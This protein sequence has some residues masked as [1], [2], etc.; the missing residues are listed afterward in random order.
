MDPVTAITLISTGL[1]VVDQYRELALRLRGAVATPPSSRAEQAGS[2]LQISHGQHV[3]TRVEAAQLRMNEWDP[4]RYDALRRR[5]RTNWEIFNVLFVSEAAGANAEE[6]VRLRA[7]MR[8]LQDTLCQDLRE[9]VKLYER[10]LGVGLPDHYQL[11]EVC[12]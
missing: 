4:T 6:R 2:A 7:E 8:D 12:H 1:K 9:M 5:I 3:I 11:Y 10:T